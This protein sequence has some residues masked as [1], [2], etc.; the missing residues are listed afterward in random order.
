MRSLLDLSIRSVYCPPPLLLMALARQLSEGGSTNHGASSSGGS[1]SLGGGNLN[2]P[3]G[4]T[5]TVNM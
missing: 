5:G 4:G 3:V 1:L 2:L